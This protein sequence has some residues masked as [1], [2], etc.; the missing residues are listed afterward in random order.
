MYSRSLDSRLHICCYDFGTHFSLTM[1]PGMV[2]LGLKLR[3]DAR[4]V[5]NIRNVFCSYGVPGLTCPPV[6]LADVGTSGNHDA[7]NRLII[8]QGQIIR[9]GDLLL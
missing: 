9:A 5:H 8:D 6:G 4:Y 1:F 2:G 3:N 7:A